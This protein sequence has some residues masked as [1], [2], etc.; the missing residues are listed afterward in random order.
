MQSVD[1][2]PWTKEAIYVYT[3]MLTIRSKANRHTLLLQSYHVLY[4]M[5]FNFDAMT[6]TTVTWPWPSSSKVWMLMAAFLF[7]FLKKNTEK[8]TK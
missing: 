1:F 2:K 8:D 5:T 6:L 4:A 7:N 3:T